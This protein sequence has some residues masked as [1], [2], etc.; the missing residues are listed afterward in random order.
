MCGLRGIQLYALVRAQLANLWQLGCARTRLPMAEGLA[1]PVDWQSTSHD[2]WR[3]RLAEESAR[4]QEVDHGDERDRVWYMRELSWHSERHALQHE[5]RMLEEIVKKG[6][7]EGGR[8]LE[9]Y[10]ERFDELA[11]MRGESHELALKRRAYDAERASAAAHFWEVWSESG[12]EKQLGT[13]EEALGLERA[14]VRA[15]VTSEQQQEEHARALER[16]VRSVAYLS[17]PE[18]AR[19]KA[20]RATVEVAE[21]RV[22]ELEEEL[23]RLRQ[24]TRPIRSPSPN[25]APN[26]RLTNRR[27]TEG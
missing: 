8:E 26:R 9:S 21:A 15:A 20:R 23:A 19:E 5:V 13:M 16:M 10:Q 18:E 7:E 11:R 22:A 27:L 14:L 4:K 1:R 24:A 3:D 25:R 12:M 6:K 17:E 2:D